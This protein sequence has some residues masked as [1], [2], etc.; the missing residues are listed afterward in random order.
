VGDGFEAEH[1]GSHGWLTING[2]MA[3]GPERVLPGDLLTVGDGLVFSLLDLH[4]PVSLE[5]EP[6]ELLDAVADDPED[7][8]RWH[9]LADWLV[10]HQAPHALLAAYDLKLRDGT[11]DPDLLDEYASTRKRRHALGDLQIDRVR[12]RCGYVVSCVVLLG[13]RDPLEP[14]RWLRALSGPQFRALSHAEFESYGPPS[15]A[16]LEALMW[17]L[18]PTVRSVGLT[19]RTAAPTSVIRALSRRPRKAHTAR[20]KLGLPAG[21]LLAEIELLASAGWSTIEWDGTVLRDRGAEL[22]EAVSRCPSVRFV[23]GGAGLH[24]EQARLLSQPNVSWCSARHDALIVELETG[25]VIPLSALEPNIWLS[26]LGDGWA[27]DGADRLLQG[28]ETVSISGKAHL[29][30]DGPGLDDQY[31]AWLGR[32]VPPLG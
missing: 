15:A 24:A 3:Q 19:L 23:L 29:F 10:E 16:R 8:T 20:L 30:L 11:G 9:V 2:R 4:R 25:V 17:A 26:R 28:G 32:S 31:R 18:P 7:R 27:A 13:P 21:E 14:D 6:P 12:W 1:L 22:K 5:D